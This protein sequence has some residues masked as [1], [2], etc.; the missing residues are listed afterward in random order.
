ME[1]RGKT[2]DPGLDD[3][4]VFAQL[5]DDER[6]APRVIAERRERDLAPLRRTW[7]G[8]GLIGGWTRD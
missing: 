8:A 3:V 1:P 4:L 6:R 2:V 5:A 7:G